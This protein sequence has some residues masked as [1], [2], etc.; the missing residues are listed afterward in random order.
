M[1]GVTARDSRLEDCLRAIYELGGGRRRVR[2]QDL[3]SRLGIPASSLTSMYKRLSRKRL[4]N[5]TPYSGAILTRK[6]IIY[7]ISFSR[8]YEFAEQFIRKFL[9]KEPAEAK[10]EAHRWEHFMSN[11]LTKAMS[12]YI[13]QSD[14]KT[15]SV[16]FRSG[17]EPLCR[18]LSSPPEPP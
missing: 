5:Y 7:S 8:R 4:I 6:G 9:D 16:I 17:V 3:S 11:E 10:R 14:L 13:G 15:T 12:M 1:E 2:I 18:A